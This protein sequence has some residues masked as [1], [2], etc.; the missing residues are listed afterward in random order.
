LKD[1]EGF[2]L[3]AGPAGAAPDWNAVN[4]FAHEALYPLAG[5]ALQAKLKSFMQSDLDLALAASKG[6]PYGMGGGV[7]WG[8]MESLSG[9]IV[10]AGYYGKRFGETKYQAMAEASRDYLFGKNPW[11]VCFIVGLGSNYPRH[12]QHNIAVGLAKDIPGMPIEGPDNLKSWASQHIALSC[13]DA[14]AAFQSRDEGGGVYHDD[15]NDYATNECTITQAG[16]TVLLF[17]QLA[18]H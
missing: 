14:Y 6:N 15:E 18:P 3:R 5:P 16:L 8:S 1:A 11:G 17:C 12:P 13:P 2:A 7:F 4:F 10:A 9:S